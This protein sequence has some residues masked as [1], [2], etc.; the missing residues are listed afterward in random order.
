MSQ[1][2]TFLVE[3]RA[4]GEW[5]SADQ[6]E[7]VEGRGMLQETI[8]EPADPFYEGQN[9]ALYAILSGRHNFSEFPTIVPEPRGLPGD[10]SEEVQTYVNW[11]RDEGQFISSPSWVT[12]AEILAFDWDVPVELHVYADGQEF[13]AMSRP[14]L[15][16]PG[17]IGEP[18][19][20]FEAAKRDGCTYVGPEEM[21]E[22][23]AEM[24][25]RY[26]KEDW[27]MGFTRE[28][29]STYCHVTY[30]ETYGEMAD[31]FL[32]EAVPRMKRLSAPEDVR[33]IFW[34]S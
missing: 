19:H 21:A 10:L 32:T 17:V 34:H 28:L 24:K 5:R 13:D 1:Y 8:D 3:Y 6:W 20:V 33:C 29:R 26:K 2:P 15:G 25:M 18:A 16:K 27:M 9:R 12:L 4:G 31:W 22:K 7:P 14:P 23:I 30:T 11:Y